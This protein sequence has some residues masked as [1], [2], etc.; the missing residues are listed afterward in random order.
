MAGEPEQELEEEKGEAGGSVQRSEGELLRLLQGRE[1]KT[2]AL[3]EGAYR[4]DAARLS[5]GCECH[6]CAN[7]SRA[8]LHHLIN[9]KELNAKI[10]ISL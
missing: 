4:E 9:V 8:Y 6:A 7:V 1:V 10:Y 5:E 2:V 3:A